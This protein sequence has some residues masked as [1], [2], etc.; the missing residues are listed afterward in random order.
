MQTKA[1]KIYVV[2]TFYDVFYHYIQKELFKENLE[3]L[4]QADK[5]AIM[6]VLK[7]LMDF[8]IFYD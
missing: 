4:A 7:G 1:L 3:C 8:S 6:Y 5:F 2:L